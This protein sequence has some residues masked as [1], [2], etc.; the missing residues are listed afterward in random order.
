MKKENTYNI[1]LDDSRNITE[2]FYKFNNPIYNSCITIKNYKDFTEYIEN[3]FNKDGSYPAFISFDF[4]L[5]NVTMSVTEDKTIFFNEESY[6][7]TGLECAEWVVNFCKINNIPIPKYFFH[8]DNLWGKRK[9]TKIFTEAEQNK[10]VS[11]PFKEKTEKP[12]IVV[13]NN[14]VP[15]TV[16]VSIKKKRINVDFFEPIR[17]CLIDGPKTRQDINNVLLT[18]FPENI[19]EKQKMTKINNLLTLYKNQGKIKNTGS[20]KKPIWVIS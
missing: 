3:R 17:K 16:M 13:K 11:D 20:K 9:I 8:D 12:T 7:E 1:F 15:E 10:T 14:I 18:C 19:S 6:Q 5:T 2:A 4:H